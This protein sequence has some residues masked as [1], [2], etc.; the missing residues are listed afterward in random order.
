ML[1]N[2]RHK[3]FNFMD[4]GRLPL[5]LR[6]V[7]RLKMGQICIIGQLAGCWPHLFGQP[8]EIIIVK[9]GTILFNTWVSF[10]DVFRFKIW[11]LGFCS[12]K[13]S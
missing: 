1:M 6:I 2:R 10:D 8:P 12:N 13:C 4:V 3:F 9:V 5:P 11:N 7:K